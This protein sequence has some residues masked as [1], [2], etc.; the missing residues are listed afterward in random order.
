MKQNLED[1]DVCITF[2]DNLK[3]QYDIALPI[4]D[5][6]S[7]KAF[8]FIYTSPLDG[9]YEKIELYR[10][11]RSKFFKTFEEFYD[12]FFQLLKNKSEFF[13]VF[14]LLDNF[15]HQKYL[16][17][18]SFYSKEDKIFRYTRDKILGEKKYFKLMDSIIKESGLKLND[19]LHKSLWMDKTD[20][21]DLSEKG[22]IVGLHSHSHPT[23][24]GEKSFDFQNENYKT[25]K[26]ILED[27]LKKDVFSM[28]HPCNS[29]N[30]DTLEILTNFNI[31][32]GFRANMRTAFNSNLEIPRIDHAEILKLL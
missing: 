3:C 9:V 26:H 15:D 28:S 30:N 31:E 24:M 20:L 7:L 21:K 13:Y 11:F 18:F 32:I 23:N 6:Y 12:S 2:D 22:H 27:V 16:S 29:Y 4:L 5:K 10:Y 17:E 19:D 8:W 14:E 25:N 1:T